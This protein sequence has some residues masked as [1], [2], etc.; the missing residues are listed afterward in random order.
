MMKKQ[1]LVLIALVAGLTWACNEKITFSDSDADEDGET[2]VTTD[3][4]GDTAEDPAEDPGL[5]PAEDPGLDPAEDPAEDTSVDSSTDIDGPEL[6]T[7]CALPSIPDDG[8][9]IYYCMEEDTIAAMRFYRIVDLAAG[10]TIDYG[11]V[12]ECRVTTPARDMLCHLT[13]WDSSTDISSSDELQFNISTP[14]VS[15]GWA[16]SDWV[17]TAPWDG[18]ANGVPVVKYMGSWL[19]LSD[20]VMYGSRCM[21][22]VT[23]P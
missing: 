14:G 7:G 23:I 22:D 20:P 21:V 13:E 5:D 19:T 9:Y 15:L 17:S 2:D 10:G 4:T 8:L 1:L 18:V 11:E 3:E 16:C 12:L 6:P